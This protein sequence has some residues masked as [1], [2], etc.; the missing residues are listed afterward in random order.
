MFKPPSDQQVEALCTDDGTVLTDNKDIEKEMFDTFFK[1]RHIEKN[2]QNFVSE[3]Y[4]E[5]NTLYDSIKDSAFYPNPDMTEYFTESSALYNPI[6]HWEV[7]QTIDSIKSPAGSFDNIEFH[8]K[9]LKGLGSNALYALSR[10]FTLCLRN[11]KFIWNEANVIFLKK[12]GKGTYAKAGSYR[13]ISISPYLGKLME[14][15][16]A[17]RLESYLIKV[18]ILDENQGGFS[19]GRNTV[20]YL[21]RLTAGIKGDINKKLTVLCLFIDF[22]KAF[23]SVWKK[24]I[25][26]KLWKVGVHGCYLQTIDNFLFER[27]V[28]LLI[29]GFIGPSRRCL[30]YGLPQGSVLS[31]LLFKFF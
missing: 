21:H 6:T 31:P 1:A 14:R 29:N 23:D 5:T 19:K 20:R 15:I 9:M 25:I 22:E 13:P 8:P 18:G 7:K 10:L 28:R 2:I 27:T 24:G 26:V 4:D 16:L 17:K 11:G 3:F 30:D 12:E